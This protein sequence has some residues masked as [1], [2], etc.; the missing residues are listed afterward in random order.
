MKRLTVV[1]LLLAMLLGMLS[2]TA[3][4]AGDALPMDEM[5]TILNNVELYPQKTGYAELDAELEKVFAPYADKDVYT[6]IKAAYDWT[7]YE[8]DFSWA[9]YSQNW[10]PA[11]DCF[12]VKHELTYDEGMQE[13]IPWEVA[14]R[15]YHAL[16]EHE[17]VCYDYASLFAVM[18]RYIGIDSYIHTGMFTFEPA[19]G[20]IV[21]HHGWV[22]LDLN[23]ETYIFD[24]QRDYRLSA[25]G[26]ATIPYEYFGIPMDKSWRYEQ[27]TE[28]NAAR[29]AQ[30]LS[31]REER[32]VMASVTAVSTASCLVAGT[33]LYPL[34]S[35]V[36]LEAVF[37]KPFL[38]WFDASG[39]LLCSD[40]VYTFVAT[41]STCVYAVCE[42]EYFTDITEDDWF[43]AH[44]NEAQAR[45]IVSGTEPFVFEANGTLTRAMAL[46]ILARFAGDDGSSADA[47]F[48]DVEK[49]SWYESAV[50]WGVANGVVTG[51]DEETFGPYDEIT[52]Q[53]FI[54]MLVRFA[55]I[56]AAESEL[57]YEDA[58][59][60][61]DYALAAMK[62]AQAACLINGYAD[63]TIR[64]LNQLTRAEGVTI[65][66]RLVNYLER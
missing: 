19:Y 58:D 6:K 10:A 64:P 26:T 49:G 46:T 45:G 9:P 33:G 7:I 66:M 20:N 22:E 30:F 36:T 35:E 18:A 2:A 53:D 39:A 23:G 14:N 15:A 31:V 38:G 56:D 16:T 5:R 57:D 28:L 27:E 37:I 41:K 3:Y 1:A 25:N 44:A 13:V 17:G 48:A 59:E 62:A 4:A 52:R 61:S 42:G 40:T 21:G 51:Y 63:G 8:I 29:D 12:A 55:K 34:D 43:F 60:I 47:G 11:Y 24:S 32:S 50:N 54:T 65:L